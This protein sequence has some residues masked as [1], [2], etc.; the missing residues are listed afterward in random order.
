ME[1]LTNE[2]LI[3]N[4]NAAPEYLQNGWKKAWR[5]FDRGHLLSDGSLI[6]EGRMDGDNMVKMRGLRMELEEIENAMVDASHGVLERAVITLR[7]TEDK[8]LAAHVLFDSKFSGD[9]QIYL[10]RLNSRLPLPQYMCP[11]VTIPVDELPYTVHGKIDRRTVAAWELPKMDLDTLASSEINE[12]ERE[13]LDLWKTVL[14]EQLTSTNDIGGDTD[15]FSVGGN[16]VMLVRLQAVLQD[17]F[18]VAIPLVDL[19]ANATL[20][21]MTKKVHSIRPEIS[22]DWSKE[23]DISDVVTA[24]SSTVNKNTDGE[25][26]DTDLS[27][28]LSGACGFLGRRVLERLAESPA[29]SRIHAIAIRSDDGQRTVPTTSSKITVHHGD[30]SW[31]LFGLSAL[32]FDTLAAEA[33]IIIHCGANRSF[34][35]AYPVIRGSNVTGTKTMIE[36][37]AG[38]GKH[39]PI[40]FVSS[41]V[42]NERYAMPPT[43]GTDAY[44]A[45][46]WASEQMLR[47]ANQDECLKIPVTIHRPLPGKIRGLQDAPEIRDML[48][49]AAKDLKA[50]PIEGGWSGWFTLTDANIIAESMVASALKG[51]RTEENVELRELGHD[52]GYNLATKEL[53]EFWE[54]DEEMQAFEKVPLPR[55]LGLAKARGFPYIAA[56]QDAIVGEGDEKRVTRR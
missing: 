40:H 15:F 27:V 13:M 29:V 18:A 4:S 49:D 8:Y 47:A 12:E 38:Q 51:R 44:V 45:S 41:G 43:D 22:I 6:I 50:V 35:D 23:T 54:N 30:L 19:F 39:T 20:A 3:D 25:V 56:T 31:P 11:S 1:D 24:A 48:I 46:K 17:R 7:G 5:T 2:K 16:S 42:V 14:Q 33:D 21:G 26:K 55:W 10:Q 36:M 37:A 28:V 9:K 53:V 52:D 34:W 32:K